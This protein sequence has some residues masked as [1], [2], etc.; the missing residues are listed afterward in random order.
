LLRS[1][2]FCTQEGEKKLRLSD[3]AL[4]PAFHSAWEAVA[5]VATAGAASTKVAAARLLNKVL[6][7]LTSPVATSV[8]LASKQ[9]S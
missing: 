1:K 4:W 7:L 8:G 9:V 6:L 5:D 2:T 3:D